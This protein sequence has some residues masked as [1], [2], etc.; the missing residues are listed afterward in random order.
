MVPTYS[1]KWPQPVS[2][3]YTQDDNEAILAAS[4]ILGQLPEPMR[5]AITR[6][7]ED[8][9]PH[10]V[11]WKVEMDLAPPTVEMVAEEVSE[12]GRRLKLLLRPGNNQH[13]VAVA[14]DPDFGS[15]V[16]IN[17]RPVETPLKAIALNFS[18]MTEAEIELT[19]SGKIKVRVTGIDY[20]LPSSAES[21]RK[22]AAPPGPCPVGRGDHTQVGTQL[23]F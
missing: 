5:H 18:E 2:V 21:L 11:A 6:P 9:L 4:A 14:A 12:D 15:D 22:V 1:E 8:D 17:G 16:T 19:T 3:T 10:Y 20:G 13:R 7:P 23:E